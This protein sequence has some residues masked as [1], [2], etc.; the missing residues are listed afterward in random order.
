MPKREPEDSI[1]AEKSKRTR[2]DDSSSSSSCSSDSDSSSSDSDSGNDSDDDKPVTKKAAAPER[3]FGIGADTG[4]R[5]GQQEAE[6]EPEEIEKTD[7][8]VFVSRI[9]P[10]WDTAKIKDYFT[11][12]F[13]QV[14]SVDLFGPGKEEKA[15]IRKETRKRACYAFLKGE[16][17]RGEW[18]EFSHEI[19]AGGAGAGKGAGQKGVI[20]FLT[21]DSV[22]KAVK[23]GTIHISTRNMRVSAYH[24]T[25]D[26]RD[27]STCYAWANF[28][29]TR[30][31]ECIFAHD[32]PGG[33][34]K[35]SAPGR[36]RTS[37][38]LSFKT[39]GK[40]SK[41]D[42]CLFQHVAKGEQPASMSAN[43]HTVFESAD[44]EADA[45]ADA[46]AQGPQGHKKK[47]STRPSTAGICDY[48]RKTG[49]CRKGDRCKYEHP[50]AYTKTAEPAEA[51]DPKP[52]KPTKKLR[53]N[54]V[55]EKYKEQ[56]EQEIAK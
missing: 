18:C 40:C 43:T 9:P 39:K 15:E 55:K 31:E 34:V 21:Q 2:R 7:F 22:D 47:K 29:C 10:Q 48:F 27:T 35:V 53:F 6:E 37:H 13:G 20:Y 24:S 46:D 30:G 26:G 32:G 50:A 23:K 45:G 28:N 19:T 38:C 17:S 33:C 44:T 16:C 14:V 52:E 8:K 11:S 56:K 4:G 49:K 12:L 5:A 41:G 42:M 1:S 51:M 3:R 54:R 25:E 36:G